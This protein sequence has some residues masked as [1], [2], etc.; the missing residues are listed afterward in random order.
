MNTVFDSS[1]AGPGTGSSAGVMDVADL[2]RMLADVA[3]IRRRKSGGGECFS[4]LA[5]QFRQSGFDGL[6]DHAVMRESRRSGRRLIPLAVVERV[7]ALAL[8]HPAWGQVRLSAALAD[9]GMALSAALVQRVLGDNGLGGAVDRWLAL[10]QQ[11][12][13]GTL[14]LSAE[15]TAFVERMNPC[16]RELSPVSQ[17]P[18]EVLDA[19][20]FFVFCP[21]RGSK[22]YLHA[23]VDTFSSYAFGFLHDSRRPEAA[24][25]VLHNTALPFFRRYGWPVRV[26][27]TDTGREFVGGAGHLYQ[28]YLDLVGIGHQTVESLPSRRGSFVERFRDTVREEFFLPRIRERPFGTL[29]AVQIAFAAW[30]KDYNTR[31]PGKGWPNM[32]QTPQAVLDAFSGTGDPAGPD[33]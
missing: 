11:W 15:Q 2:G 1:G 24:T 3:G 23:V 5:E 21:G 17:A 28:T 8:E 18:G 9:E 12:A 25:A 30:L 26:V 14:V 19:D 31:R 22:V 29:E 4:R 6:Q 32:G 20:S 10:E 7:L 27:R 13:A 16:F 33:V